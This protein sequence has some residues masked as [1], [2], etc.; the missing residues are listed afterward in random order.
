MTLLLLPVLQHNRGRRGCQQTIT[1][2]RSR[3]TMTPWQ[4]L[5]RT[6]A[7]ARRAEA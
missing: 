3:R 7:N 1:V 2:A 6:M 5:C 4:R